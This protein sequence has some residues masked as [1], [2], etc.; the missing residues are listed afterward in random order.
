LYFREVYM[1]D[2]VSKKLDGERAEVVRRFEKLKVRRVCCKHYG[3]RIAF[4]G[5]GN[6]VS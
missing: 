1:Y 3:V 6:E 5:K 4:W 2:Y